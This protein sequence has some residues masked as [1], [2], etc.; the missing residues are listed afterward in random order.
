MRSRDRG[1]RRTVSRIGGTV[2]GD[3]DEPGAKNWLRSRDR[4]REGKCADR[5][6]GARTLPGE[7]DFAGERAE[8]RSRPSRDDRA[9]PDWASWRLE[10]CAQNATGSVY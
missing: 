2:D 7:K 8:R 6:N 1:K 5:Q 4:D 9:G 3:G 10:K